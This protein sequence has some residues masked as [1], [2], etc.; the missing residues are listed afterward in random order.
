MRDIRGIKNE[1]SNIY[2]PNDAEEDRINNIIKKKHKGSNSY[3]INNE[4]KN[5]QHNHMVNNHTDYCVEYELEM[6][7]CTIDSCFMKSG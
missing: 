7:N 1:N 4:N 2:E 3:F 5:L 6:R